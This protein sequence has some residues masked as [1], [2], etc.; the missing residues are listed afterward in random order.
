M[1]L[2]LCKLQHIWYLIYA[3]ELLNCVRNNQDWSLLVFLFIGS[4]GYG[5]VWS[6][7]NQSCELYNVSDVV[8]FHLAF[9][10]A[11]TKKDTSSKFFPWSVFSCTH[12][13]IAFFFC[14]ML[15]QLVSVICQCIFLCNARKI[16]L[17]YDTLHLGSTK[18]IQL[19][20][21]VF[22]PLITLS[23]YFTFILILWA[24]ARR[25]NSPIT[26]ERNM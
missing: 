1:F 9:G 23:E 3:L 15:N 14:S 8:L 22:A 24:C 13:V 20:N 4:G 19:C 12:G 17:R 10:L 11:N 6:Y 16:N 5:V 7:T 21:T 18:F 26:L 2:C 25:L